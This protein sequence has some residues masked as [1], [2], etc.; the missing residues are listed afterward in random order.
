RVLGRILE[1]VDDLLELC[2]RLV[3]AGDVGEGD[4]RQ[5]LR[6]RVVAFRAAA[7]ETE[8]SASTAE[9]IRRATRDPEEQTDQQQRRTEAQEQRLPPG[10]CLVQRVRVD[11]DAVLLE[12]GLEPRVGELRLDRLDQRRGRR[13]WLIGRIRHRRFECA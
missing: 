3:N 12:Q 2:F 13:V 11:G 8:R 1:E 7:A 5:T 4:F 10:P 9:L 6:R